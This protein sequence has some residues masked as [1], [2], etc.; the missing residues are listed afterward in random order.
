MT[1]APLRWLTVQEA[2][3]YARL[4]PST[5]RRAIARRRLKA[6]RVGSAIRLQRADL[7]S[8]LSMAPTLERAHD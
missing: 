5:I 6:F 3:T 1:E 2:A 8:W 7:D 4:S